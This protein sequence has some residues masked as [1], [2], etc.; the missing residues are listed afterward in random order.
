LRG[1]DVLE[2]VDRMGVERKRERPPPAGAVARFEA[3]SQIMIPGSVAAEEELDGGRALPLDKRRGEVRID[4]IRGET[5]ME[6]TG[7]NIAR[8]IDLMKAFWAA[9]EAL[10]PELA[11]F[12]TEDASI[13]AGSGS[14]R[15]EGHEAVRTWIGPRSEDQILA[16]QV[17]HTEIRPVGDG[18]LVTSHNRVR[19]DYRSVDHRA[20]LLLVPDGEVLK[21]AHLHMSPLSS[22][23]TAEAVSRGLV[24]DVVRER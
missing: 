11:D 12:F 22:F 19:M 21:I 13:F 10:A 5:N 17:L 15:L 20:T 3:A 23:P 24:E 6:D 16:L 7:Q 8:A 4:R 14:P 9:Y 18:F 1:P 2:E